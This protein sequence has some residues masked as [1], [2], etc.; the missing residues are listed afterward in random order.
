[1]QSSSQIITTNKSTSSFLQARCHFCRPTNNV[2]ALKGKISHSMDLL[3]PS[4]PGV[5]Q[6]LSLTNDSS[7][8]PRGRVAMPLISSLMPVP[9]SSHVLVLLVKKNKNKKTYKKYG[10]LL[11][12]EPFCLMIKKGRLRWF[13]HVEH[14]DDAS[15]IRY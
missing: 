14:K 2:K 5:F 7:W 13:L 6:L 11:G 9:H 15:C 10:I 8:L 3:T 4:S 12:L 1:M